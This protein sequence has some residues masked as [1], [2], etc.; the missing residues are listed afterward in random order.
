MTPDL[1]TRA[2]ELVKHIKRF[3]AFGCEELQQEALIDLADLVCE[4]AE[5]VSPKPADP[6][7]RFDDDMREVDR[8]G[9]GRK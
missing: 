3:D 5:A 2:Q 7:A 8:I 6:Y 4:L 1:A 9:R